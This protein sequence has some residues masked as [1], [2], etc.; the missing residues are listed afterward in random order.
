MG[1]PGIGD[2]PVSTASGAAPV[3]SAT[4]LKGQLDEGVEKG[5][6]GDS[7]SKAEKGAE[8]DLEGNKEQTGEEKALVEYE[9]AADQ[10]QDITRL[11]DAQM[12]DIEGTKAR[13]AEL[14]AQMG[15]DNADDSAV[16]KRE[17]EV[18]AVQQK[19]EQLALAMASLEGRALGLPEGRVEDEE[20]ETEEIIKQAK[21]L[22]QQ[23]RG[24]LEGG[25]EA[26]AEAQKDWRKQAVEAFIE[27]ASA[28][29]MQHFSSYISDC[30]NNEQAQKYIP[31]KITSWIRLAA[32]RYIEEGGE[33]DYGFKATIKTQ[34]IDSAGGQE[35]SFVVGF[36]I[37]LYSEEAEQKVRQDDQ[38]D[39]D[40][41]IE[42]KDQGN[43]EAAEKQGKL[44]EEEQK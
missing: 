2:L 12:R 1:E 33:P 22:E 19:A 44:E 40:G 26:A 39:E 25:D 37:E 11:V 32:E 14:R 20:E 10:L 4:G 36:E 29:V 43:L 23:S 31:Q 27:E 17:A 35:K 6:E 30:E 7:D 24:V 21:R 9:E 18:T 3:E 28:D 42:D 13:L 16:A 15:V 38:K 34:K 41:M 8:E 5:A